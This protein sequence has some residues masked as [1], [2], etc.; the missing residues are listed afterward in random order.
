MTTPDMT[1]CLGY[2]EAAHRYNLDVGSCV[3][4]VT[5]N[6]RSGFVSGGS[7]TRNHKLE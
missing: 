3:T 2:E 5:Y 7:W 4:T 6:I 1:V